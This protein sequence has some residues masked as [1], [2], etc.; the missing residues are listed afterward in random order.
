MNKYALHRTPVH[1]CVNT[2]FLVSGAGFS[3]ITDAG[4]DDQFSAACN[5]SRHAGICDG[6]TCFTHEQKCDG[7]KDC[8]D[9]SDEGKK[10]KTENGEKTV[11]KKPRLGTA[12]ILD[13]KGPE[14]K[15]SLI[16]HSKLRFYCIYKKIIKN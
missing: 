11:K 6:N 14:Q 1:N 4:L 12:S 10:P 8:T 16:I 9:E 13:S 3:L 5:E 2:S 15:K 7:T